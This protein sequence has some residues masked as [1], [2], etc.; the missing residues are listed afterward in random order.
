MRITE[1]V[2]LDSKGRVLLPSTMREAVGL[3]EGMYV[4]LTADTEL[5]QISISPFADLKARLAQFRVRMPDVPG[6]LA[7]VAQVLADAGVDLIAS[8]SRTLQREKLA[9][10]YVIADVSKV[11]CKLEEVRERLLKRGKAKEVQVEVLKLGAE[12]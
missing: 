8:E 7:K 10:W 6:S 5:R 2:R 1:V 9:E 11:S 3:R 12:K 4:M